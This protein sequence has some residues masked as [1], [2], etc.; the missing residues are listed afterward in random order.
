MSD[1]LSDFNPK[2]GAFRLPY[3]AERDIAE[4]GYDLAFGP[5]SQSVFG[6]DHARRNGFVPIEAIESD[7]EGPG[8]FDPELD[9]DD[10]ADVEGCEP[11]ERRLSD[12]KLQE[13]EAWA[14][15]RYPEYFEETAEI[16]TETA[17]K[18]MV[19]V[20]VA[21][22]TVLKDVWDCRKL[23]F[24]RD[25]HGP[26]GRKPRRPKGERT[27]RMMTI[28][29]SIISAGSILNGVEIVDRAW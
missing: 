3:V 8:A 26:R 15:A 13:I 28:D 14:R 29:A 12:A 6:E 25:S 22:K 10:P 16:A 21:T 19:I 17:P 5:G 1:L 20:K 11:R 4:N 9:D 27:I 7:Y 23:R 24:M 2:W 18:V